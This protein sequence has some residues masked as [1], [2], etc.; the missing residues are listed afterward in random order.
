MET[1][2]KAAVDNAWL[3]EVPK[4]DMKAEWVEGYATMCVLKKIPIRKAKTMTIE[5]RSLLPY[6]Q[7]HNN[8]W[9]K[10]NPQTFNTSLKCVLQL[11][12]ML[13]KRLK[14]TDWLRT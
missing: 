4:A 6:L 12:V 10:I 1:P 14:K 9:Y 7:M 13:K 3:G 11:H 2:Y 5:T 8:R